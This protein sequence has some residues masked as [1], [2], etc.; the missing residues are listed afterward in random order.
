MPHIWTNLVPLTDS[1]LL[2]KTQL[3]SFSLTQ[4]NLIHLGYWTEKRN[5]AALQ[6]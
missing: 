3:F 4:F 2:I 5:L 1:R 6:R